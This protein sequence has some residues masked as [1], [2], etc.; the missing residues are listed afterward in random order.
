MR[1]F[2]AGAAMLTALAS[3]ASAQ[4]TFTGSSTGAPDPGP[5][6]SEQFIMNFEG[7]PDYSVIGIAISAGGL[8]TGGTSGSAAEPADPT[9]LSSNYFSTGPNHPSTVTIDFTTWLGTNVVNSLSFYWG[10]IDSY[11]TLRILGTSGELLKLTGNQVHDPANGNQSSAQTN[12]RVFFTFDG[13][14]ASQ[15]R[16]LEFTSTQAA[17]EV[18]DIAIDARAASQVPEPASLALLAAGLGALGVVGA[19]RKRNA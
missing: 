3:T 19:R 13:A 4:V 15:F 12:R 7:C 11:N 14:A 18:D 8:C 6:A 16:K 10:S 9:S 17:F 1:S 5:L 2:L